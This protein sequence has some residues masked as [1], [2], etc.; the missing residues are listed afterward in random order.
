MTGSSIELPSGAYFDFGGTAYCPT[1]SATQTL[2]TGVSGDFTFSPTPPTGNQYSQFF[3]E[4]SVTG[5]TT[6]NSIFTSPNTGLQVSGTQVIRAT[7]SQTKSSSVT[8]TYRDVFYWGV[9]SYWGP[10]PSLPSSLVDSIDN[11]TMASIITG[12]TDLTYQFGTKAQT[13]NSVTTGS[14]QR[15]VFAYPSS[16]ADIV[17]VATDPPSVSYKNSVIKRSTNVTLTTISGL[18]T[19]YKVYVF[20]SDNSFSGT[21]LIIS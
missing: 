17:D 16:Y 2:P 4:S 6:Y 7:G 9:S 10:N 1:P 20:V 18:S 15:L 5:T 14:G 12:L 19:T 11:A 8:V 13:L 3:T 21:K